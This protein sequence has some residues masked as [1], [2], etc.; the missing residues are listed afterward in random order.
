MIPSQFTHHTT[1]LNFCDRISINKH[2]NPTSTIVSVLLSLRT[3]QLLQISLAR[4]HSIFV[5]SKFFFSNVH[6]LTKNQSETQ[7]W[8]NT[9]G[10]VKGKA[11][12][13][14][15]RHSAVYAKHID[16]VIIFGGVGGGANLHVL[17]PNYPG[18]RL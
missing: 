15:H 18:K 17:D 16:R 3:G 6:F 2:L 4:P 11:P 7:K 10:R 12:S 8:I 5:K 14:R 1:S 13:P 9:R